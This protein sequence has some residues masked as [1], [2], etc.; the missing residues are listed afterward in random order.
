MSASASPS[1]LAQRRCSHPYGPYLIV[2][3]PERGFGVLP[4]TALSDT[5]LCREIAA[6]NNSALTAA[7]CRSGKIPSICSTPQHALL[8]VIELLQQEAWS[9]RHSRDYL[10]ELAQA[11]K[12]ALRD[13]WMTMDDELSATAFDA[14]G[15]GWMQV[16][17]DA[18]ARVFRLS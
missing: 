6:G 11:R 13:L 7:C 5:V 9:R 14:V 3:L 18:V 12:S 16:N 17:V 1:T 8:L 15:Q 10:D 2:T 4:V